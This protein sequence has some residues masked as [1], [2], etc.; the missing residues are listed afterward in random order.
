MYKAVQ[1]G[2]L[3]NLYQCYEVL[4]TVNGE[5]EH[6]RFSGGILNS[7]AW[8][9]MCA[10]IFQRPLEVDTNEHASLMGGAVLA[11]ENLGIIPDVKTYSPEPER[12]IMPDPS[13]A[14]HYRE[15]YDR[16]CYYYNESKY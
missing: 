16:Y 15:K 11:M 5:P 14:E 8:T 13:K 12:I 1:E 4:S 3:F 10:D 2:V 7:P 9:Q 6:I